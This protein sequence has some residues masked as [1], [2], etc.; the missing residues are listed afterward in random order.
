MIAKGSVSVSQCRAGLR[1]WG[2][3]RRMSSIW[4]TW[5]MSPRVQLS[6]PDGMK[7]Y[8][9]PSK[10][11]KSRGR[12]CGV[13]FTT[14]VLLNYSKKKKSV[15]L[16]ITYCASKLH[17]CKFCFM[18]PMSLF[19]RRTVS[20]LWQVHNFWTFPQRPACIVQESWLIKQRK[21]QFQDFYGKAHT[22]Y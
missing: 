10:S 21:L 20:F 17:Q 14:T 5:M 11:F 16:I 2:H 4:S 19:S 13:M 1:W 8:C 7:I 6:Q 18:S 12:S 22:S 15:M 9:V 3:H